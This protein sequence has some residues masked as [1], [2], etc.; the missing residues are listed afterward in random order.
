[1]YFPTH[2]HNSFVVCP[3]IFSAVRVFEK[4]LVPT[5]VML[6]IAASA[7]Q[8]LDDTARQEKVEEGFK[9]LAFWVEAVLSNSI[10]IDVASDKFGDIAN[11]ISNTVM[12]CPD[13][14]TDHLLVQLLHSKIVA[15]T[16]GLF[17][18]HSISIT[19]SDTNNFETHFR[20]DGGY[21][22]PSVEYFPGEIIHDKPWWE[23]PTIE[24]CE[25]PKGIDLEGKL[26]NEFSDYITIDTGNGGE[27]DIIVLDD[28]ENR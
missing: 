1:M 12:F 17:D 2:K 21:D 4:T 19:T 7:S 27:A 6:K 23:R 8:M 3:Y 16:R 28:N 25:F 22:L 10:I 26:M 20:N 14:P 18:I 15:I 24:V 11:G 13:N 9:K 5:D